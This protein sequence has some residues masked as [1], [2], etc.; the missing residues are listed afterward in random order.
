MKTFIYRA[1]NGPENI[2]EGKIVANSAQEV[3][4]ILKRKGYM[5]TQVYEQTSSVDSAARFSLRM[6]FGVRLKE[7]AIFSRQ[8]ANLL[9]SGVPI[10]KALHI[11]SEQTQDAYF[12]NIIIDIAEKVKKGESLSMSLRSYP[13]IFTP[14]YIAMVKAGE[15]SGG[16]DRSL[17][18]IADYYVKQLE[19]Q[20][21][22]KSALAYPM[23]I[24][25]VG[26]GSII[27]IFT[28]VMPRIIPLFSS[29]NVELPMPT[30]IL[31][32][33]SEFLQGNWY[34][35]IL[36][37]LIF[38]LIFKKAMSNKVFQYYIS[39]IKLRL[40]IFGQLVFKSEVARFARALEMALHSGIPIIRALDISL[41]IIN[42]YVIKESLSQSLK[43]LESGVTLSSTLKNAKIFPPFVFNLVSVGEESGK[44]YEALSDIAD[45]FKTDCEDAIKTLTTLLEPSMVLIIGLIVGFIVTAVLL[46]IFQLN[47][48]RL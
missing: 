12:R 40:P 4:D 8:L 19:L 34:Y 18:R 29:L 3:V 2:L 33:I 27:F 36:F 39:T 7:I 48:M 11:L 9:K 30:R 43:D 37:V 44:L 41:P 1:K 15:D 42:E 20:S 23:L 16:V 35:L 38:L 32:A 17:M 46:P 6:F 25:L 14:F 5:A 10:L 28:N 13:K 47:F 24:L 21:K 45:S 31:I 26:I 22:I